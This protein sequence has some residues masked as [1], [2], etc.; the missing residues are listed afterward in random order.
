MAINK[1]SSG[2]SRLIRYQRSGTRHRKLRRARSHTPALPLT[3]GGNDERRCSRPEDVLQHPRGVAPP[4]RSPGSAKPLGTKTRAVVVAY[5]STKNVTIGC[6]MIH[7]R[8]DETSACVARSVCSAMIG[9]SLN[10]TLI[11]HH[12]LSIPARLPAPNFS[13]A[14]VDDNRC[15]RFAKCACAYARL[16][17]VTEARASLQMPVAS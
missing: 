14:Q 15:L 11:R 9:P 7:D 2:A 5:T 1:I 17:T 8:S 10:R 6:L 16:R 3:R 13:L 12:R 4:G